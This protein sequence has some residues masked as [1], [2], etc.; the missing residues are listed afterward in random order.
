MAGIGKRFIDA[1]YKINK[2]LLKVEN[3]TTILEKIFRNFNDHNTFIYL[4]LS[5]KKLANKIRL[6][7]KKYK[8]KII[9]IKKHNKG[10]LNS[11]FLAR[12]ILSKF[13]KFESNIFVSYSDIN[14][15]WNFKKS[16]KFYKKRKLLFSH[17]KI[18]I[19][20]LR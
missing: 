15:K 3:N 13:L 16:F 1:N 2:S 10:P 9:I 5:N 20:I 18:F 8:I 12:N 4:I 17:I 6:K 7:F 19:L 14:W 11:I